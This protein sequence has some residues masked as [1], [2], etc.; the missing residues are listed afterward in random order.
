MLTAK[1]WGIR[2]SEWTA[3]SIFDK[4]AMIA[5]ERTWNHMMAWEQL[6]A[7]RRADRNRLLKGQGHH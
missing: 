5:T 3:L 7:R 4:A 2:P 6:E 1:A